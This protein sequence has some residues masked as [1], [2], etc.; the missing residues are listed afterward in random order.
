[1]AGADEDYGD[2]GAPLP[3]PAKQAKKKQTKHPTWATA[4]PRPSIVLPSKK[5]SLVATPLEEAASFEPTAAMEDAARLRRN[6]LLNRLASMPGSQDVRLR[7]K[8][9][10]TMSH[11][12]M[13]PP[14]VQREIEEATWA[15]GQHPDPQHADQVLGRQSLPRVHAQV[16]HPTPLQVAEKMTEDEH[17]VPGPEA[18]SLYELVKEAGEKA[19][20]AAEAAMG[21]TTDKDEADAILDEAEREAQSET[22]ERLKPRWTQSSAYYKYLD[23]IS[24]D[25][26]KTEKSGTAIGSRGQLPKAVLAFRRP[27]D[28]AA[29]ETYVDEPLDVVRTD[30]KP[31]DFTRKEIYEPMLLAAQKAGP[32]SSAWET[33]ERAV[34]DWM[35]QYA[36]LSGD[37]WKITQGR[38]Q[39]QRAAFKVF[40]GL[41]TP[42]SLTLSADGGMAIFPMTMEEHRQQSKAA[43]LAKQAVPANARRS[44]ADT[45][46]AAAAA[47]AVPSAA[48]NW[49]K[50]WGVPLDGATREGT[51]K[52]KRWC[53]SWD[54]YF[55]VRQMLLNVGC[56]PADVPKPPKDV[57]PT[58][59]GPP[60]EGTVMTL[61]SRLNQRA[62]LFG[63]DTTTWM[64]KMKK[65]RELH[66]HTPAQA[67]AAAAAAAAPPPP[68]PAPPPP[69]PYRGPVAPAQ[70]SIMQQWD[71]TN[72][73][74]IAAEQEVARKRQRDAFVVES[75]SELE[76][77]GKHPGYIERYGVRIAGFPRNYPHPMRKDPFSHLSP[78]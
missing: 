69:P 41:L 26:D 68:A 52:F 72:A 47:A 20:S 57:D 45:A 15:T 8:L 31:V 66:P 36:S 65:E 18:K 71:P 38:S 21:Q 33:A 14:A 28:G 53:D 7:H 77:S 50:T 32:G 73:A 58:T 27:P 43:D 59:P 67:E 29:L 44:V 49:S 51:T 37:S 6:T 48:G 60:R 70:R 55:M 46:A 64:G 13:A 30:V 9:I 24:A 42:N 76:G 10:E 19:R 12:D 16:S 56:P 35:L 78:F 61:L 17:L 1:M 34:R 54:K 3:L 39:P 75:D 5:G 25:L 40:S 74:R 4:P 62:E 63:S 22:L 11:F 23:K 2:F